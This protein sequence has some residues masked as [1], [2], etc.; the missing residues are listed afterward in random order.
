MPRKQISKCHGK[1]YEISDGS[2][3]ASGTITAVFVA[4]HNKQKK[5]IFKD[6]L[7]IPHSD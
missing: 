7:K 5:K 6:F 3:E 4:R 2:G 1:T